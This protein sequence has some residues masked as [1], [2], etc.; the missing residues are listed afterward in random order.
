M[1]IFVVGYFTIF[2]YALYTEPAHKSSSDEI[3]AAVIKMLPKPSWDSG[4]IGQMPIGGSPAE[5]LFEQPSF[6]W[7]G[8][9]GPIIFHARVDHPG[10]K[11]PVYLDWGNAGG[12]GQNILNSGFYSNPRVEIGFVDRFVVGQ[13]L[14]VTV[15]TVS[16]IEGS[17]QQVLQ[18]GEPRYN[19]TKVGISEAGYVARVVVFGKDGKEE[20]YP[21][22]IVPRSVVGSVTKVPPAIIGTG[23]LQGAIQ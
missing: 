8:K 11:L 2:G 4:G 20:R 9:D 14:S 10:E 1:T 18:W 7:D 3:A 15:G 21:F 5:S 12:L 23:V 6:E 22:L 19:N 16:T 13:S 17:Q